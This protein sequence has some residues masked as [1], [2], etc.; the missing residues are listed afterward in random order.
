MSEF[1][2]AYEIFSRACDLPRD[3]RVSLV[4]EACGSD[5]QLRDYVESLLQLD[6]QSQIAL[7][8]IDE[9]GA[10]KALAMGVRENAARTADE[11]LTIPDRVGRYSIVGE[12]GRGGMGVVFEAVQESPRRRVA[13]KLI[14]QG[15]ESEQLMGRLRQEAHVLGYL[16]HPGIA[17]IFEAGAERIGD[18]DYPYLAMELIEGQS[19]DRYARKQPLSSQVELMARV[20]DAVQ[21]AHQ[22]GVVHR[23]LKPANILVAHEDAA[24]ERADVSGAHT[25]A[26]GQP[27][28]MDFGI[29]RLTDPDLQVTRIHTRAGQIVGTLAYMS[30]EQFSGDSSL[31]DTRCDVY[32]LGVVLYEVLSGRTPYDLAGKPIAEAARIIE[33]DEPRALG[34]IDRRLRG[35]LE[36]IVAKAMDKDADRRYASAGELATDLRRFLRDEPILAR[37]SSAL[38]HVKKFARRH[39]G[40]VT[41]ASGATVALVV[42]MIGLVLQTMETRRQR[43]A[44]ESGRQEAVRSNRQLERLLDFQN[45]MLRDVDPQVFGVQIMSRIQTELNV[46]SDD[47]DDQ[48]A[49]AAA[50][51]K[52]SQAINATNFGRATLNDGILAPAVAGLDEIESEPLLEA[53]L[54]QSLG[55][56]YGKLG[57]HQEALEQFDIA[58]QLRSEHL[59]AEHPQT[60]RSRRERA[61]AQ[62]M[63]G[64]LRPTL[65]EL[66]AVVSTQRQQLGA[67]HE[68]VAD[69]LNALGAVCAAL[70]RNAEATAA[71]E[72]AI[73]ISREVR[74]AA[75]LE[76]LEIEVGFARLL[77]ESEQYEDA[78]EV[79]ERTLT[80]VDKRN[81]AESVNLRLQV[82]HELGNAYEKLGAHELAMEHRRAAYEG[83]QQSHGDD[84]PQTLV[85]LRSVAFGY[86]TVGRRRDAAQVMEQ[87]I[88]S[89]RRVHGDAHP[90]TLISILQLTQDYLN[91]R[92]FAEAEALAR[93]FLAN[94]EGV[95]GAADLK[96]S[97]M[98]LSLIHA[99][100]GQGRIAE[101]LHYS[102]QLVAEAELMEGEHLAVGRT[103][104][105]HAQMLLNSGEFETA[106]SY[107]DKA[108]EN[109][110]RGLGPA[111]KETV[112]RV[113]EWAQMLSEV[114]RAAE[115]EPFLRDTLAALREREPIDSSSTFTVLALLGEALRA[116]ERHGDAASYL[117]EALAL[118]DQGPRK[119]LGVSR[120]RCLLGHSL[121]ETGQSREAYAFLKK[122]RDELAAMAPPTPAPGYQH[123]MKETQTWLETAEQR[124]TLETSQGDALN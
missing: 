17:Q 104:L 85:A 5:M 89:M 106:K 35:D 62:A 71:Y 49:R 96:R 75:A 23:D 29:A 81:D 69:S 12:L 108:L 102:T 7:D 37:P 112:R 73:E 40:L 99:L 82:R 77:L 76:T 84:H 114:G 9:G 18:S 22:K 124:V 52:V 59:G 101:A 38:Y 28:V 98:T 64:E 88:A 90:S 53:S 95:F 6:Q 109:Y 113:I 16:R 120:L 94:S 48:E 45:A 8:Q 57:S 43:D 79:L 63:S 107:F 15:I 55:T 39:R 32:A 116:Q 66:Q 117:R 92:Q 14:R 46:P 110:H 91:L 83:Y 26:I 100:Y 56:T 11:R 3:E 1:E 80:F 67:M 70:R 25:D 119:S 33:N 68:D 54:R 2:R 13:L 72:E 74:G 41:V 118:A 103:M 27:K 24:G 86:S 123:F 87:L 44:A 30:P 65:E 4:R 42:L 122:G 31:S 20:C 47:P 61:Y 121:L 111:N 51:R 105:M 60:L 93:E 10:A 36:T 21:H 19:L 34:A 58:Y 50:W 97:G 78:R 115:G